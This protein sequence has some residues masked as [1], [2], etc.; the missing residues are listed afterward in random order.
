M[1]MEVQLESRKHA[2]AFNTICMQNARV[3]EGTVKSTLLFLEKKTVMNRGDN[4]EKLCH[5]Q[6]RRKQE[7]LI[8]LH[9]SLMYILNNEG[10][11][12]E[13]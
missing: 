11:K 12:R 7:C 6:K 9:R 5:E 3:T 4:D 13:S 2:K 1:L 8:V 10:P